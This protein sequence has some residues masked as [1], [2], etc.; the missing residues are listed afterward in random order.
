MSAETALRKRKPTSELQN[1][2][3]CINMDNEETASGP[4]HELSEIITEAL[5]VVNNPSLLQPYMPTASPEHMPQ[6]KY[7]NDN[8]MASMANDIKII[9][10]KLTGIQN[11]VESIDNKVSRLDEE[12]KTLK[13]GFNSLEASVQ[14]MSDVS[15]RLD[16]LDVK[17]DSLVSDMNKKMETLIND[18]LTLQSDLLDLQT[19][20]MRNNLIFYNIKET[21][22]EDPEEK[23][24][25]LLCDKLGYTETNLPEMERVHRMGPKKKG[26]IRPIVAR[27]AHFKEKEA[28]RKSAGPLKGSTFGL[29]EQFPKLV[30]EQRKMLIPHMVEARKQGK[31]AFLVA[32]KL[33]VDG[34]RVNPK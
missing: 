34:V 18:N 28:V 3:K 27:F 16:E 25:E 2:A 8:G 22:K 10:E 32:D 31:K 14:H 15:D 9:L 7:C 23:V 1:K 30:H 11:R 5:E 21:D 33:Y 6:Q 13:E 20:S 17:V 19:R 4:V 12:V 24:Q 26:S 29:S